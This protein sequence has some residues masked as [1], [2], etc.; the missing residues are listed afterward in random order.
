MLASKVKLDA[1]LDLNIGRMAY[2]SSHSGEV[3]RQ[4]DPAGEEHRLHCRDCKASYHR[5]RD[6]RW[7]S[8]RSCNASRPASWRWR[9]G[10][11][12]SGARRFF[13]ASVWEQDRSHRQI[14]HLAAT[15]VTTNSPTPLRALRRITCTTSGQK[16]ND[17]EREAASCARLVERGALTLCRS[18][19]CR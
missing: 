12:R 13:G 4:H 15:L 6:C 16:A 9:V 14:F 18:H 2:R 17:S 1:S 7:A 8:W 19:D 10:E 11:S 5:R 3:A